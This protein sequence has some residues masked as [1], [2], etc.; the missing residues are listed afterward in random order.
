M[1]GTVLGLTFNQMIDTVKLLDGY[2]ITFGGQSRVFVDSNI[3]SFI[4]A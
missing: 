3:P 4:R 1:M 2:G